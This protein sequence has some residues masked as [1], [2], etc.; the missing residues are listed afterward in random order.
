MKVLL[1]SSVPHETSLQV[2]KGLCPVPP[3]HNQDRKMKFPTQSPGCQASEIRNA[4]GVL[5]NS[6]DA[7][8]PVG[9]M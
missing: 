1:Y 8:G 2:K 7:A 4:T 9:A 5:E 3:R 6:Q